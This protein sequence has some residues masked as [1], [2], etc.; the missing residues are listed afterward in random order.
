MQE[1]IKIILES[2][3]TTLIKSNKEMEDVIKIVK[4][5]EDSGLLLK[6]V[7]G[8]TQNEVKEQTKG[9]LSMLLGTL[10]ASLLENILAGKGQIGTSQ[11]WRINRVGKGRGKNRAG[12]GIVRTR[13]GNKKGRKNKKTDV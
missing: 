2:G 10:C 8:T 3:A 9:F 13:Y 5:L 4:S 6:R 7:T 1:Y 11:G 12:E